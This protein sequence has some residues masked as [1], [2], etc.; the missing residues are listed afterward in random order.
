MKVLDLR[1]DAGHVF[2][3]WFGSEEDFQSQRSRGLLQCPMCN[4]CA[5]EKALSAP[6]LKA[7]SNRRPDGDAVPVASAAA[8]PGEAQILAQLHARWL[9]HARAVL[10][11][12]ENVGRAFADEARRIHSGE[13]PE[14]L[15]H[16]QASVQEVVELLREGVPVLPLP[17]AASEPLQ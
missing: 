4:S 13:A 16:G 6:R 1:C 8:A 2:E 17:E 11:E 7:K 15:I 12:G 9:A 14:R 10:R 3:G 5:V